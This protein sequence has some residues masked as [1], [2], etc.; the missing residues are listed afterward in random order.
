MFTKG[1]LKSLCTHQSQGK[2]EITRLDPL[3]CLLCVSQD[4]P[5][6]IAVISKHRL[7]PEARARS[8]FVL[9]LPFSFISFYILCPSPPGGTLTLRLGEVVKE[10]G[11]ES[12]LSSS[13]LI[14]PL[15][16]RLSHCLSR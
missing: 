15:C 14:A 7:L 2:F 12:P 1:D 13:N 10:T 16:S 11:L 6:N 9:C 4:S 3:S 5:C 8:P